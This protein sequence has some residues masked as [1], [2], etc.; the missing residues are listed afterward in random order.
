MKKEQVIT[1]KR[2]KE[3]VEILERPMKEDA[4]NLEGGT[5]IIKKKSTHTLE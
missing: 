2:L 5:K 3:E 1:E 4:E